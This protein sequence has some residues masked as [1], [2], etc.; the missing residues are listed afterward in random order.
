MTETLGEYNEQEGRDQDVVPSSQQ[1][2]KV[3][4]KPPEVRIK[5]WNR[6]SLTSLRRNQPVIPCSQTSNLQTCETELVK[7]LPEYTACC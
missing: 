4:S 7:L 2:P 6:F 5:D 3:A 1:M